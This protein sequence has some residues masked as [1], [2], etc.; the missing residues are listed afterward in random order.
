[1]ENFNHYVLGETDKEI[2]LETSEQSRAASIQMINSCRRHLDIVSRDLD[3]CIYDTSEMLD[4]IKKLALRSRL[5]RVRII[6]LN[7]ENLYSHGHRLLDL[8]ERLSSFIEIRT[9]GKEHSNFNKSLLLTDDCGYI[10]RPHSDRF[11][12]RAN[13]S[14]RKTVSE[15]RDEFDLLWEHGSQDPNFRQLSL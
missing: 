8:S 4:A 12:G 5:S 11:E 6:I 14:D 2:S 3:P 15:L 13:F 10:R 9:P 1:M 7:P